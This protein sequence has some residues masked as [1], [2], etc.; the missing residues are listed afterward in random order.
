MSFTMESSTGRCQRFRPSTQAL[1]GRRGRPGDRAAAL[2]V[3]HSAAMD[4]VADPQQGPL[5]LPPTHSSAAIRALARGSARRG[6]DHRTA[7][8]GKGDR[9]SRVQPGAAQLGQA[10]IDAHEGRAT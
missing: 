5:S 7:G 8:L 1:A 10:Q 9:A 4:A 2:K 6:F 3:R